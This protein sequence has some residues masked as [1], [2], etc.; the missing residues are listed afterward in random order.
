[1]SR[2]R[3]ATYRVDEVGPGH[4]LFVA[5]GDLATTGPVRVQVRPL[6]VEGVAA[7]AAE[8]DA[9]HVAGRDVD[10][11]ELHARTGGN[12]FFVTE[13]LSAG[14]DVVPET[15]REA[16]LARAAGLTLAGRAALDAVSAV[17]GG[18]DLWL[19]DGLGAG[20]DGRDGLDECVARGVL[21]ADGTGVAFRHEPARMAVHDAVPPVRR[22][23]LHRRAQWV[24]SY[25][26][27]DAITCVYVADSP[28]ALREHAGCGGF[29]VTTIRRVAEVID[30][31]TAD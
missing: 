24:Q 31:T 3:V 2:Q 18:T 6:S 23:E 30:P 11:V 20:G 8:Q 21:L 28:E 1:M 15:V 10:P 27:D 7:L 13:C 9:E 17:P 29:P 16:V 14:G 12:P 4:P 5:L 25:V 26:T 22:R 19:A